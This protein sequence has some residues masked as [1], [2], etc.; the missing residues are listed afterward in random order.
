M[1]VGSLK[2]KNSQET[3]RMDIKDFM[4]H[5]GLLSGVQ[6]FVITE[7]FLSYVEE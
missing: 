1:L 6:R 4:N 2:Q 7:D 3:I 5:L